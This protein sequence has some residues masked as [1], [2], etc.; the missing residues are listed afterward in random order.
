[1]DMLNYGA[2]AQTHFN[3]NATNLVNAD[4]TPEQQAYGTQGE[5]NLENKQ[6]QETLEG[7]TAEINGKNLVFDS[8]VFLRYRMKFADGQDMK[9]VSIVFTYEDSKGEMQTQTV[10]ASKFKTSGSYYTADCTIIIP[11]DMRC[12]VSATI[13]DGTEP[14]SSTLNYSIETYVYNRLKTSTSETY[15]NL[16]RAMIKYGISAENHFS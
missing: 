11:S 15:K 7:A 2:A 5:P 1:M 4:L 3:K 14:I 16:I 12:V 6:S 13:Y 10:K 9:K 8:S